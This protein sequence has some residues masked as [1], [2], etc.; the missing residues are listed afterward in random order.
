LGGDIA[1]SRLFDHAQR[2]ALGSLVLKGSRA[3]LL[4][5]CFGVNASSVAVVALGS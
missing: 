1:T 3:A 2:L 4:W 5:Q